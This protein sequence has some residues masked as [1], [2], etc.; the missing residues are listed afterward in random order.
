MKLKIGDTVKIV[1][2]KDKGREGK[3]EMTLPKKDSVVVPEVNMY[4]KH[5]KGQQGQKGGMYDLPR[6]LNVAKVALICPNCKKVTRVGFSIVKNEKIRV[7]KKC[8]KQI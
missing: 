2:G 4:K 3:I 8:K 5:V 7:C 6:P 1:A